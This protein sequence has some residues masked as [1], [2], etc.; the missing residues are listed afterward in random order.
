MEK[1]NKK[2]LQSESKILTYILLTI[3]IIAALYP[4]FSVGFTT[5]DDLEYYVTSLRSAAYWFEDA[6]IYAQSA[7]RFHYLLVKPLYLIPYLVDNFLYTKLIQYISLLLSYGV[8]SFFIYKLFKSKQ[9]GFLLF[10]LLVV[11][12]SITYNNHVPTIAYP[13]YFSFSFTLCI[14]SL[15]LFIKYCETNKC[16]F[17]LWSATV[18]FITSLFYETYILFLLFFCIF[19]FFRNIKTFGWKKIWVNQQF[20][21]EIMPYISCGILYLA[22]YV[23]YRWYLIH[24]G[25]VDS[26]YNGSSVAQNFSLA[27]FFQILERCTFFALPARNFSTYCNDLFLNSSL[28]GGHINSILFV[29]SHANPLTYIEAL[30]ACALF[31]LFTNQKLINI[32]YTKFLASIAIA[33]FVA[34][35]SHTLIGIADKYNTDWYSWM[36]GYVTSF[37]S[38][39]CINLAIVL[40]IIFIL[41]IFKSKILFQ[42]NRIVL[43]AG[44]FVMIVL[45]SY[46]NFGLSKEWER[47]Q[48]RFTILNEIIDIQYFN[49]IPDN[50]I[51]YFENLLDKDTWGGEITK[52]NYIQTIPHIVEIK[53]SKH[54][55]WEYDKEDIKKSMLEH[56][57]SQVIFLSKGETIKACE[58]MLCFSN[59]G[60]AQEVLTQWPDSISAEH[61]D[62]FYLSPTKDY[63]LLYTQKEASLSD[64]SNGD[65]LQ[66]TK[67]INAVNIHNNNINRKLTRISLTSSHLNPEGFSISNMTLSSGKDVRIE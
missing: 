50:S 39:F 46:T 33:L 3:C 58:M 7:G 48:N 53:S 64:F 31:F 40:T 37:Y 12:T 8:F 52:D 60:T 14:C 67:G 4:F 19:L 51:I 49:S 32:S 47:S 44:L 59:L 66:S 35:F 38:V 43:C 21:K 17:V 24:F 41:N 13:F 26:F 16:K 23:S 65:T 55:I 42:L 36:K 1:I 25:I 10:I 11:G 34:F 54:F 30:A 5:G 2:H 28:L 62:I 57:N 27:H 61:C 18:F 56:P 45:V 63:A 29:L 9:L 15:L 20:Y 22:L 6:Q